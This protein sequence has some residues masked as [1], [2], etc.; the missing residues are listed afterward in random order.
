MVHTTT[1]EFGWL[2]LLENAH[3]CNMST[4]SIEGGGAL[5][6]G[7]TVSVAT[8]T[9]GISVE[10]DF[11]FFSCVEPCSTAVSRVSVPF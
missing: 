8:T 7:K 10:M 11:L 4:L 3:C 2:A 9:L 1:S 6:Q 5:P